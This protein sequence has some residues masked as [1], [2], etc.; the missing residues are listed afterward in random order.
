[1]PTDNQMNMYCDFDLTSLI[2][3]TAL[4]FDVSV[5]DVFLSANLTADDFNRYLL[6]DYHPPKFREH[7]IDLL[8]G[9]KCFVIDN[10]A[11]LLC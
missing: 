8:T 7:L 11:F 2:N 6:D 4:A 1:M 3:F 5:Y 10:D 9:N